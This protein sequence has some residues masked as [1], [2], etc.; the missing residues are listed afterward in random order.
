[1]W[2]PLTSTL[3]IVSILA[4][5]ASIISW[6]ATFVT[7]TAGSKLVTLTTYAVYTLISTP[8]SAAS[9]NSFVTKT[10]RDE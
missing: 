4:L 3:M 8:T 10:A 5:A 9:P 7:T 6:G 1:M 2:V